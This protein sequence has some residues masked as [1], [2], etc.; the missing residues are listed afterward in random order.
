MNVQSVVNIASSVIMN[1]QSVVNTAS[2]VVRNA[3]AVLNTTSFVVRNAQA[4]IK[5][6]DS[7]SH[8]DAVQLYTEE[9]RVRHCT[10]VST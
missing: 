7:R 9:C 6:R 10:L 5:I 2:S 1:V 4:V 3:Q 8:Y